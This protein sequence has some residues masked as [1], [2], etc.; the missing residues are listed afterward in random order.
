LT[1]N[2]QN[3]LSSIGKAVGLSTKKDVNDD[4][5]FGFGNVCSVIQSG[6]DNP[7]WQRAFS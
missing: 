1:K 5:Y 7:C 4:G 3:P 2:E 6:I